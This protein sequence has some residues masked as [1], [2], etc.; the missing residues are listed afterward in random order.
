M[1]FVSWSAATYHRQELKLLATVI[2]LVVFPGYRQAQTMMCNLIGKTEINLSINCAK[3]TYNY[4]IGA[5]K[6]STGMSI[7]TCKE[8]QILVVL[9][10]LT[11]GT[12]DEIT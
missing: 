8:G 10:L 6:T 3:L 11:Q 5:D 9:A 7:L 12:L 4:L 1:L 2:M